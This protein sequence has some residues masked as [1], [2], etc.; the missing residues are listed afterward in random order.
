LK[1][2]SGA[3]R[4]Y[5]K[6]DYSQKYTS[7]TSSSMTEPIVADNVVDILGE[8]LPKP[9]FTN[10]DEFIDAVK[11]DA[12]TFQPLGEKI[13]EYTQGEE[14]FEIYKSSFS[15]AKFREYHSRLQV[16]VLLFIEGSSYIE[17]DDEKWEIY[18]T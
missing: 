16:F 13:S 9:Y 3:L 10:H 4:P 1:Y 18:T 11:S 14:Q 5:F 15:S 7:A 6:I 8:Y 17:D 12:E 2:T